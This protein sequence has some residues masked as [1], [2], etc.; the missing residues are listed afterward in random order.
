MTYS[1]SDIVNSVLILLIE[2]ERIENSDLVRRE[3]RYSLRM[4]D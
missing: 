3:A 2:M 1:L 4:D